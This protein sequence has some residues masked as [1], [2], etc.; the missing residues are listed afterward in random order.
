M[1]GVGFSLRTLHRNDGFTGL[2]KLY[3]A[4]GLISSGPWLLSILTL[5]LV[6]ILGRAL[7][8]DPDMLVRFQ[9]SVTWLFAGSLV[10][11]GP[12]QLMFT[13][14][15][16]DRDY[17]GER[18]LTVPNLIGA[19]GVTSVISAAVAAALSPLF[20]NESL[21]L[22]LLLG[23]S[24]VTLCDLWIVVVV[25]TGLRAHDKVLWSFALGYAVTLCATLLLARF[26]VAGL[27]GGFALGQSTLLF[28]SLAM[29]VRAMPSRSPASFRFLQRKSLF[30][31][32]GVIGA[33]YNLGIWVDKWMFWSNAGTSRAVLGPLRSSEVY[34]LP[35]FLAYLTLVPGMAVFLVRVETDFAEAHAAF[36]DAVRRGASLRKI[37]QLCNGMTDSARRAVVGIMKVQGA[38]FVVGVCLGP[39]MLEVAGIS[40]LH[41]P[42]FY[43]DAA[44]V[45]LQVLL[46]AVTSMFFYLDRRR[47]VTVLVTLLV[48]SNAALTW[49]SQQLGPAYY[50]YGFAIAMA[51]TSLVGLWL[52]SR[53]FSTLVRD[54]FMLQRSAG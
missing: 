52:L 29:V 3:G 34:D 22:K 26:G 42:L 32:L 37:Q 40:V 15:I 18:D 13:R 7:V 9:V 2:F 19:L 53:A 12:L 30:I 35:I 4:A 24:F 6:G 33:L 8:P 21:F 50:G 5:L 14:F 31:E 36:Y 47:A 38:S 10:L 1:A 45:A 48:A 20:A 39:W 17:V 25:L 27:L 51:I 16:A 23:T 46:L 49:V 28:A 44:G 54:T 41:L 11:S 43:I